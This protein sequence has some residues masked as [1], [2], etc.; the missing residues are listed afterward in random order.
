MMS[1]V[2][3]S[4]ASA[5]MGRFYRSD[6]TASQKTDV[7]QRLRCVSEVT[8]DSITSHFQSPF[9]QQPLSACNASDFSDAHGDGNCLPLAFIVKSVN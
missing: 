4:H 1:F 9:L 2:S 8:G 3:D 5:R 6:T 7:I